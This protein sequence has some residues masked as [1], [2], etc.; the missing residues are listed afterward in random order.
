M[1]VLLALVLPAVGATLKVMDVVLLTAVTVLAAT[2]PPPLLT[3]I[4]SPTLT[5]AK[6]LAVVVVMVVFVAIRLQ[7]DTLNAVG[8]MDA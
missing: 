2:V 8:V 7:P 3:V 1:T 6:P 4:T 5:E